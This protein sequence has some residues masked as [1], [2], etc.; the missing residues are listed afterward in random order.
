MGILLWSLIAISVCL[1]AAVIFLIWRRQSQTGSIPSQPAPQSLPESAGLHMDKNVQFTVYRPETVV[2]QKWYPLLAFAHLA[3]RRAGATDQEPDPI[4][5]VRQ[6]AARILS[7]QP[8]RY[9]PAKLDRAFYV[10]RKGMLTFVPLME[11]C[12]FNPPSQSILWQKDVHKVEFEMMASSTFDGRAVEGQMTIYLGSLL[13]AEVALRI[14]V[15]SQYSTASE[16]RV[17]ERADP[18]RKIF[19]SYSH[20]DSEI[21]EEFEEVVEALGDQF[22][23]DVKTLRSGE[24][25]TEQLEQMI[26]DANIFQL[27]WSSNSMISAF[28]KQEWE[29]ALSLNRAN[30]I[31]PV[32]WEKRFPEK[33][34]DLPPE[35][36]RRLHF[37]RLPTEEE[38]E[39][40]AAIPPVPAPQPQLDVSDSFEPSD[41]DAVKGLDPLDNQGPT[42]SEGTMPVSVEPAPLPSPAPVKLAR[43]R[44]PIKALTTVALGVLVAAVVLPV[45]MIQYFR[46][47]AENSNNTN[48][49]VSTNPPTTAV[50][51]V[52]GERVTS[53]RR[54]GQSG[55]YNLIVRNLGPGAI[56][57]V[58]IFQQLPPGLEYVSSERV[59]V[60]H[61][62]Q[63][64]EWKEPQIRQRG[65]VR[66]KIV[67]RLTRSLKPQD[68]LTAQN[69]VTF[70]DAR[71]IR[72]TIHSTWTPLPKL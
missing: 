64:L 1:A 21:V 61:P 8:A 3:E 45:A 11:G 15:D 42:G 56:G 27:F 65:E 14:N 52:T 28:V 13:L 16:Q 36:L 59:P 58:V 34:P 57:D 44:I 51:E 5:E 55:S 47:G 6:Q 37:H 60:H 4:E 25:W 63:L 54:R 39:R 40:P 71:G 66:I 12:E 68:E 29:Y 17:A 26:R 53:V 30:F 22:L 48:A 72:Q 31:R 18:Y 67:V 43:R 35:T 9:E 32:Y 49:N 41:L 70:T 7:E 23:R 2:P 10:P 19:A 62:N 38:E 69:T 50:V 46:L 24:V 20:R 33:K